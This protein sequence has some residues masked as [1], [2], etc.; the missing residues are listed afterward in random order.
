RLAAEFDFIRELRGE[1][2]MIGID[3]SVEGQP[4]VVAALRE[5]LLI[6]CTHDHVLR[7]LPP[8]IVSEKQ[9]DD[10]LDRFRNVLA[11]TRR[12]A[13]IPVEAVQTNADFGS[14]HALAAVR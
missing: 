8:F 9:V 2:L 13:R 11:Q 7:L 5:G 10:F 4:Y 14:P 6:N 3:L 12:P 1:G